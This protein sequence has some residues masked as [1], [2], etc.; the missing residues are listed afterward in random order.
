MSQNIEIEFKN[1]LTR[2]EF[3]KLKV[4]FK[5]ENQQFF[6][7]ENHYFDTAAFSLKNKHSALRIREK[8]SQYEMTLKQ[9]AGQGLLE[10]NQIISSSEAM[11]ALQTGKLPDG[12]I[13][14]QIEEMGLDFFQFEYFGS[15]KTER[16]EF[17]YRKGLLVLDHSYY[18]NSEDFEVE[19]EVENYE[20]G[21]TIFTKFLQE[22]SIPECR[23]K[24]KIERFYERKMQV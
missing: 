20:A 22:H 16:V 5:L 17:E 6:M 3:S 18:L 12:F 11:F 24:N 19:Y 2:E 8:N 10:S 1:L 15:L 7:Q 13:R 9:P 23:T 4:F 14:T 21:Q